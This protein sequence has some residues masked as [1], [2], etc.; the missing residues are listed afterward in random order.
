MLVFSDMR[1]DLPEGSRR[2]LGDSEFENTQVLA[3][4][5]KRLDSDNAD[6]EVF[7]GRLARWE[8]RVT[9]SGAAGWRTFM[10]SSQLPD[11]LAAIR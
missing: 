11:Y 4:N 10:D 7:R 3:M 9:R 5:V 8:Q 6:P 2:E 1:E